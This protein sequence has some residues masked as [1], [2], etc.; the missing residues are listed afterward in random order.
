MSI[1]LGTSI[2]IPGGGQAI[3][4]VS[5]HAM[6]TGYNEAT[7]ATVSGVVRE[8][9]SVP[10]LGGWSV[11][12]PT[13]SSNY[14]LPPRTDMQTV[15]FSDGTTLGITPE[16]QI[17]TTAGWCSLAPGQTLMEHPTAQASYLAPGNPLG[18]LAVGDSVVNLAGATVT[19]Q[20]IAPVGT[21]TPT[22]HLR[23]IAGS[24]IYFANGIPVMSW[25]PNDAAP[26]A[27]VAPLVEA[28]YTT[29]AQ[30]LLDT[31]AQI[32]GYDGILSLCSYADDPSPTFAAEG[33]AGKAW[34][35]AVWDKGYSILAQVQAQTLAAPTIPAFLALLPAM[36][37]PS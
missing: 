32:R 10:L 2:A 22:C 14:P 23:S 18:I 29:A 3:E 33:A 20:S 26:T 25:S 34:R 9:S 17:L 15:E 4:N 31:T 19:V 28:D 30:N 35:S 5:I 36:V 6:V 27:A 1:A 11:K 13:G 37:W 24:Y 8:I 12:T 7:K 16:H 21:P